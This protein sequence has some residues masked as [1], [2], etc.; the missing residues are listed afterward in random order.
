LPAEPSSWSVFDPEGVWL[1]DV[2]LPAGFAPIEI[3]ADYVLGF[4]RDADE[5]QQVW[6]LRLE[7]R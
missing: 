6:Q 7:R 1:G 3:G 4:G 2:E 5:N